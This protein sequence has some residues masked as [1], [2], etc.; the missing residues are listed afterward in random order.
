MILPDYI[1]NCVNILSQDKKISPVYCD[2]I[3][4][5]EVQGTEI[6]PEWSMDRLIQGPFI[7]NCSM[8]R[9]SF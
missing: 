1:Y 6:R 2:T 4:I 3:H 7:V 9:K 5:G 8:F